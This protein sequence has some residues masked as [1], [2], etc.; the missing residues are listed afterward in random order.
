ML[1]LKALPCIV[2]IFKLITAQKLQKSGYSVIS[3]PGI[4]GGAGYANNLDLEETITCS[5]AKPGYNYV[6]IMFEL[7]S[8]PP[9]VNG[10]CSDYVRFT[11]ADGVVVTLCQRPRRADRPV[12]KAPVKVEFHTDGVSTTRANGSAYRGIMVTPACC[13]DASGDWAQ[14][15]MELDM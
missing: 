6:K 5:T 15:V 12:M 11:D 13:K 9:P 10:V 2:L 14:C 7:I 3:S 4:F 8:L 1:G